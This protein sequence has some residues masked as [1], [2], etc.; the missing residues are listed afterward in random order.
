[1]DKRLTAAIAIVITAA[2]AISFLYSMID[3]EWNPPASVHILMTVVAGAAFGG[4]AFQRA[5][6]LSEKVSR[7]GNGATS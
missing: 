4:T 3:H 6:E 2:W 1:M 7:E 5:R